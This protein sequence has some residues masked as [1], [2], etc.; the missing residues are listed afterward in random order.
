MQGHCGQQIPEG[1]V[2]CSAL[3]DYRDLVA[4]RHVCIAVLR[5]NSM[6]S[7]ALRPRRTRRQVTRSRRRDGGAAVLRKQFVLSST[8]FSEVLEPTLVVRAR[9]HATAAGHVSSDCLRVQM[10]QRSNDFVGREDGIFAI[11]TQSLSG[12]Q[13]YVMGGH[14]TS[15]A[16]S[17]E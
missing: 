15:P 3:R 17:V 5:N 2:D 6:D 14:G 10:R 13:N 11:G 7:V 9:I 12:F 8:S 1:L 4:V 16:T